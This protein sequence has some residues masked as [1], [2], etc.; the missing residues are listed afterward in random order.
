MKRKGLTLMEL[1]IVIAIIAALAGLLFP[2]F[3]TVRE[4]AR[5]A[6]CTNSLKQVGSALHMYA[7]DYDGF[8]PPYTNYVGATGQPD[9]DG[10]VDTIY[11]FLN[12]NDPALFEAA[13][14]P[15][16]KDKQIWYCPLDP[17]AGIDTQEMPLEENMPP[18]WVS[19]YWNTINHKATSYAIADIVADKAFAPI[20]IDHVPDLAQV[21]LVRDQRD[22]NTSPINFIQRLRG[23]PHEY[24]VDFTHNHPSSPSGFGGIYLF[25]DGSVRVLKGYIH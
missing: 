1:L 21:R 24:A 9:P 25:F 23:R 8:V 22:N 5:I 7:Q 3:V 12:A 17:F 20:H 18:T 6:H 13:Y 19:S 15:Y 11:Y 10:A 16:T 4:R 2:V 14:A